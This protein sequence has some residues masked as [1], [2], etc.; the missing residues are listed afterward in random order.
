MVRIA[1]MN[2]IMHGI[3]T[4]NIKYRDTLGKM[5]DH[6]PEFDVI[7]MN[8]PFKGSIDKGDVNPDFTL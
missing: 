1:L 7:L 4:P 5:Y 6:N 2:C 3:S 8:P